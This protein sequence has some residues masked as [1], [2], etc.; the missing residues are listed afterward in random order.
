[1]TSVSHRKSVAKQGPVQSNDIMHVMQIAMLQLWGPINTGPKDRWHEDLEPS[2]AL[3]QLLSSISDRNATTNLRLCC[4]VG[5]YSPTIVLFHINRY[6]LSVFLHSVK[7]ESSLFERRLL[8]ALRSRGQRSCDA[9]HGKQIEFFPG[10]L[11]FFFSIFH[12]SISHL[13]FTVTLIRLRSDCQVWSMFT[14]E[15]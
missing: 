6:L 3:I 14:T 8:N 13:S 7:A 15:P 1:M 12:I 11:L 2:V 5:Q 10:S 9:E 4:C